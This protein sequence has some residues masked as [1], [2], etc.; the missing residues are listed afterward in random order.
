MEQTTPST[1]SKHDT[2]ENSFY[3]YRYC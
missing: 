2:K 3:L 1:D